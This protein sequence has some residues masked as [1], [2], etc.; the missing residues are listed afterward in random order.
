MDLEQH[1][2]PPGM[3]LLDEPVGID[4]NCIEQRLNEQ[5]GIGPAEE[6]PLADYEIFL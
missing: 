3:R 2:E 6:L 4:P 1:L 5:D